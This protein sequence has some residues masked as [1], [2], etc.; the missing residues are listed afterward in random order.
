M[1][2][3]TADEGNYII[4]YYLNLLNDPEKKALRHYRSTYKLEDNDEQRRRMYL[5]TGWLSTDPVILDYLK[6]GYE[7]FAVNCA[8]RI[9][10]DN[11]GEVI[12]NLCP[13]CKKLARTPLAKQCRFCGWDWH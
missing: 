12:F 6:D 10:K 9:L 4:T 5:K 1:N 13:N 3:I 8:K 7:Q 2:N 11:P